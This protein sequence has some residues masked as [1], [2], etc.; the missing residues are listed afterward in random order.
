VSFRSR[1]HAMERPTNFFLP[2]RYHHFQSMLSAAF[3]VIIDAAVL[4]WQPMQETKHISYRH[5]HM[6]ISSHICAR[7]TQWYLQIMPQSLFTQTYWHCHILTH[8]ILWL[9]LT[10]TGA[11]SCGC[12]WEIAIISGTLLFQ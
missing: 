11:V 6:E 4:L 12:G 9:S 2:C 8:L 7:I 10:F 5:A 1:I 3:L